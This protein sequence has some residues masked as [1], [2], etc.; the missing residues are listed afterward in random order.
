M[1]RGACQVMSEESTVALS[2]VIVGVDAN[3]RL[4][5]VTLDGTLS[6]ANEAVSTFTL[7]KPN[8]YGGA[9]CTVMYLPSAVWIV[10]VRLAERMSTPVKLTMPTLLYNVPQGRLLVKAEYAAHAVL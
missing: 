7:E 6:A 8:E 1:P 3:D 2:A 10:V 5:S 9:I 4:Y